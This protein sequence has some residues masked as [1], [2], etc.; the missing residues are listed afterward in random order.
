MDPRFGRLLP[1]T[2]TDQ[3][4]LATFKGLDLQIGKINGTLI[5]MNHKMGLV[6]I[7]LGTKSVPTT[8]TYSE[9]GTQPADA[10]GMKYTDSSSRTNV[11]ASNSFD[12]S[13]NPYSFSGYWYLV[14]GSNQSDTYNKTFKSISTVNT[15]WEYADVNVKEGE[16]LN[17][18]INND[19]IKR[20]CYKFT[21]L[22]AYTGFGQSFKI[23]VKGTTTYECWGASGG[24]AAHGQ[25]S[26]GYVL[27]S[28]DTFPKW[29]Q[30]YCHVGKK[31]D[32]RNNYVGNIYNGGGDPGYTSASV[33]GCG[34]GGATDFRLASG[35]WSNVN[36][37]SSRILVAG[38]GGGNC[39]INNNKPT[40]SCGGGLYGYGGLRVDNPSLT[41]NC[42]NGGT[43]TSGGVAPTQYTGSQSNGKAGAFG[44]GGAGG[45]NGA[46]TSSG[47]C[48]GGGGYYGG[49]GGS[50]YPANG[51]NLQGGGGSSFISGH[52]GC[53][54]QTYQ[55]ESNKSILYYNGRNYGF[56]TTRM[57]D[58]GGYLWNTSVTTS[59]PGSP[60]IDGS[61]TEIGH[62][63]NGYAKITLTTPAND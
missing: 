20:L 14:R 1:T 42:G 28:T 61:S 7:T 44:K 48:G 62:I 18:F 63:G 52:I 25:S 49:S 54:A 37:L 21:A 38:G 35:D 11:T 10:T 55:T 50:G 58:G 46:Y 9:S 16:F 27:G 39:A 45:V 43:P 26:G 53:I 13:C 4:I 36:G 41:V 15:D 24:E 17:I 56:S 2:T 23:P 30:L 59:Q 29:L 5:P 40:G 51:T 22:F 12:T 32:E 3:S 47:G 19:Y 33:S 31:G 60:T 6:K 8:R 34:G 57:I